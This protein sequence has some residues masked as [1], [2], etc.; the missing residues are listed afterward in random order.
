MPSPF[1]R[2]YGSLEVFADEVRAGVDAG[3]LDR[4]DLIGDSGEG[5]ILRAI[6]G[7]HEQGLFGMW[8]RDRVWELGH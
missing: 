5:G 1:E 6:R 7:W 2:A 3:T 4:R 8:R